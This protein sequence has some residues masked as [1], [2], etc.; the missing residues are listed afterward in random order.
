M[1]LATL[2]MSAWC[3]AAVWM[4]VAPRSAPPFEVAFLVAGFFAVPGLIL[5]LLTL[6]ARRA[7]FLFA[8]VPVFSNG[9]VL[10]LPWIL[11]WL[12][13]QRG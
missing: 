2:A 10:W 12:R 3:L 11:R 5:G 7:W 9:I 4:R 6:R 8:C 13:D 1:T